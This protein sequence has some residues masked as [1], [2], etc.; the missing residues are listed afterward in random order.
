ML[1]LYGAAERHIVLRNPSTGKL[2]RLTAKTL[3]DN[4]R[5]KFEHSLLD[6][7]LHSLSDLCAIV[8]LR[9][10]LDV[11]RAENLSGDTINCTRLPEHLRDKIV[12]I[13][14]LL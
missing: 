8:I 10:I 13:G 2:K 3:Q 14:F 12:R 6:Q 9:Q 11:T 5:A 7:S 1:D 4:Y